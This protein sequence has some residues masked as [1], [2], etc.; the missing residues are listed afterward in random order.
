MPLTNY[1][2]T[3]V[4]EILR[5]EGSWFIANLIRLIE[6]ADKINREKLRSV[7]PEVV[8][9]FEDWFHR[10]GPYQRR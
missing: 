2:R 10:R 9:A 8:E 5:G 1:D 6:K 4:Q 3:H 7:Y